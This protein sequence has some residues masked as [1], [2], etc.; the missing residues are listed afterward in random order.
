MEGLVILLVEIDFDLVL[1]FDTFLCFDVDV[2]TDHLVSED[3][4]EVVSLDPGSVRSR[5]G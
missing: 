5:L 3:H 1:L 4:T 2:H